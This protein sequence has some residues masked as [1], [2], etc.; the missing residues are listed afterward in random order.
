MLD[1]FTSFMLSACLL[2][3]AST[4]NSVQ[5]IKFTLGYWLQVQA[6][7]LINCFSLSDNL[8]L[9]SLFLF[10]WVRPITLNVQQ[11]LQILRVTF[12]SDFQIAYFEAKP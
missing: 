2:Y 8:F 12:I 7:R 10:V 9:L 6:S 3:P 4:A 1:N 5:I 11:K